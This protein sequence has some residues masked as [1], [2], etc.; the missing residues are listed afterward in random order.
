M[1]ERTVE[2]RHAVTA[3]PIETVTGFILIVCG[4][5]LT[6]F[7]ESA[8]V[9]AVGYVV[10]TLGTLLISWAI[11]RAWVLRQHDD[12][13]ART[14][15]GIVRPLST[16]TSQL[17]RAVQLAQTVDA[18]VEREIVELAVQHLLGAISELQELIGS[19]ISVEDVIAIKGR[20]DVLGEQLAAVSPSMGNPSSGQPESNKVVENVIREVEGI[21]A[22]LDSALTPSRV[23]RRE[24]V[25]CPNCDTTTTTQ[26]GSYPGDSG[27]A[28]C[29][30]VR[31]A[32][33]Y[34]VHR[35]ASGNIFSKLP[36]SATPDSV[37]I[38]FNC[39][40][41]HNNIPVTAPR[42]GSRGLPVKRFCLTCFAE[43]NIDIAHRLA[44]VI[45]EPVMPS[46]GSIRYDGASPSITCP[47]CGSG[48]RVLQSRDGVAYGV[49]RPCHKP[50][51]APE[52]SSEEE[53]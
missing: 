50:L 38:H 22:Q 36:G 43:L 40:Q 24:S 30:N 15:R 53:K 37:T 32:T 44:S 31:C 11:T 34:H 42:D 6:L 23:V 41:C 18:T 20:L 49:C 35:D 3:S 28:I 39:P 21:R 17:T 5:G 46:L 48:T 2:L 7:Q 16:V 25:R 52:G 14:L 27:F 26:L 51:H 45:C 1:N 4:G 29:P 9:R 12:S 33:R 8:V 47:H 19:P 13:L 10:S